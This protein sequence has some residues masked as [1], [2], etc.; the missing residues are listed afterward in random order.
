[1]LNDADPVQGY[2]PAGQL[3]HLICGYWIAQAI[4]VAAEIGIADL[5]G[6]RV[7]HIED[8]ARETRTD[9]PSLYRLLRALASV[10]IFSEVEP[11]GFVQTPMGALLQVGM[12]GNLAAFSRLQGAPWHWEA[13]G[14]IVDSVRTGIPAM[15]LRHA[16]PNCFDYLARHPQSLPVFDAAMSG[17]AAQVNA[18]VVDAYDFSGASCIVDVGGGQGA[19]LASILECAPQARGVLFDRAEVIEHAQPLLRQ[20]RVASRCETVA[21]DFFESVPEGGDAYLLSSILHDWGDD[22]SL[23]IL[24]K[25]RE[26]MAPGGNLLI[27]EHVLPEGD[28]PH[29]GKLIDLEMMLITGGKERTAGE[30]A[31]LLAKAG[32]DKPSFISTA[33][34]AS[35]VKTTPLAGQP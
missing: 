19:L 30:Y 4:H 2:S 12:P 21:G 11:G 13:W 24:N 16:A 3:L 1:M 6:R 29:P 9:G 15:Q 25:I 14:G 32:F 28:E 8:L 35:I 31:A 34:S 22:K 17:Y 20:Y 10:G 27:V 33:S 5:L 7:R 18:A 26:H 23:I